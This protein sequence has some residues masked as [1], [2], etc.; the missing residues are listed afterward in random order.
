[1]TTSRG[2]RY[3]CSARREQGTCDADR[4]I[5]A[6]EL[7]ERVLNGLRDILLGNEALIDEFASEFKRELK[8]HRKETGVAGRHLSKEL[9]QVERGIK[10]CL[11][12]ITGGDGDPGSVREQLN[13]LESRK[14]ELVNELQAQPIRVV[15]LHPNLADLY[16]RKIIEL[17]QILDDEATRPRAFDIIRSLIGHIEVHPTQT[18]GH[19]DVVVVGALAQFLAFAQQKATAGS[20]RTDGTSL[21]VAGTRSHLYRTRLHYERQ[22]RK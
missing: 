10:R 4:G 12:F 2:V 14:R 8:R 5:S 20:S 21:M 9:Q 7:E 11:D 22:S 18:R 13:G 1:M 19:C 16:R 3:Y 6:D 15:E 17:K